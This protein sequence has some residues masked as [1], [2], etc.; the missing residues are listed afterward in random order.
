VS[1]IKTAHSALHFLLTTA[2]V[3][4]KLYKSTFRIPYLKLKQDIGAK[5]FEYEDLDLQVS[6][7][8]KWVE[9]EDNYEETR[10]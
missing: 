7:K 1:D 2:A 6:I 5:D 9:A 4:G 8:L 3:S 10:K